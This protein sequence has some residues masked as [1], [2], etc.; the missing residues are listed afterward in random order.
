M[1]RLPAPLAAL[2]TPKRFF[3]ES[4]HGSSLRAAAIV[5]T[6]VALLV[7]ASFAGIGLLLASSVDATVTVDNPDRPP[8]QFCHGSTFEMHEDD[9]E[10]PAQIERDAGDLLWEVWSQYVP[11]VFVGMY[12]VWLVVGSLLWAFARF[13]G[14]TESHPDTL[15]V[16]GWAMLAELPRVFSVLAFVAW[17]TAGWT[18]AAS[19]E[20]ELQAELETLLAAAPVFDVL[21]FVVGVWQIAIVARGLAETQDVPTV[22]AAIAAAVVLVPVSALAAV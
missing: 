6:F 22:Q 4:E 2:L 16:W 14:A 7:T 19:S 20:A 17:L 11:V 1:M 12:A 5:V 13:F 8:E 9:C 3:A 18:V 21:A 15:A 10:E